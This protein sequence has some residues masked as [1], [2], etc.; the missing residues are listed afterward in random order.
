M[1][2]H[3]HNTHLRFYPRQLLKCS[4]LLCLCHQKEQAHLMEHKQHVQQLV[5]KSKS[6]VRLR[7]RNPEEKSNSP[8]KVQALC[9]FRQ[10]QVTHAH[11]HPVRMY[12]LCIVFQ[13]HFHFFRSFCLSEQKV[14]CKGDLGILKDNTER[15]KWLV[16]GPGGL[17]ME[18]PS[19]CLIVPPP[20]PLSI[21]LANKYETYMHQTCTCQKI[22]RS[23]NM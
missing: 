23:Y 18:V 17:D 6:I 1:C 15:S 13:T 5:N 2:A 11:E 20:N 10:D 16:T 7:P 12:I 14:I 4:I 8:V 3:T 19:V 9:D 21:S 22:P